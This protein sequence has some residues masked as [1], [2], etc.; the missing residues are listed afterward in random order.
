MRSS[1]RAVSL[2]MPSQTS[3]S[4]KTGWL[5]LPRGMGRR[6]DLRHLD[7]VEDQEHAGVG[8]RR[9]SAAAFQARQL[10]MVFG[11]MPLAIDE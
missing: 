5:A 6:Q 2:V 9:L 3:G 1:R 7:A 10:G 4:R 11:K 8:E